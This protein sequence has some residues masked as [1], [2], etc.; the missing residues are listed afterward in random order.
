[1]NISSWLWVML[2]GTLRM[3]SYSVKWASPKTSNQDTLFIMADLCRLLQEK[4]FRASVYYSQNNGLI[5]DKEGRDWD[6][7]HSTGFTPYK[8]LFGQRLR[9]L[10]DIA[11]DTTGSQWLA[12]AIQHDNQLC[13][14]YASQATKGDSH[15]AN[16]A[17]SSSAETACV[18]P[19]SP[20]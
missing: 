19:A 12:R 7:Q 20:A 17:S 15:C 8:L 6:P 16:N 5:T 3:S 11:Q 4:N 9:V 10:L 13:T 14:V 1:M 2:P 18:Q